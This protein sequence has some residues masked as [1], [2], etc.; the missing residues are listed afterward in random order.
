MESYDKKDTRTLK[1]SNE[2]M[3]IHLKEK[4]NYAISE[5]TLKRIRR[6]SEYILLKDR[7]NL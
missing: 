7:E 3:M 1:V 4:M 6:Y 2:A 5:T